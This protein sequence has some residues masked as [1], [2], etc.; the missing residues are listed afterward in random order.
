MMLSDHLANCF[1]LGLNNSL[2]QVCSQEEMLAEIEK[3]NQAN[4]KLDAFLSGEIEED[5]LLSFMEQYVPIDEYIENT[6]ANL[7][8]WVGD[9]K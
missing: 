2:I 1:R 6:N 3:I 7:T 9:W 4:A 5:D 8:S